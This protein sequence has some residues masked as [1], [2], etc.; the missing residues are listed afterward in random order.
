MVVSIQKETALI[1][2]LQNN[3]V[4]QKLNCL[5]EK[6]QTKTR[7]KSMPPHLIIMDKVVLLGVIFLKKMKCVCKTQM[8]PPPD[9]QNP[10]D[11]HTSIMCINILQNIKAVSLKL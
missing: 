3:D 5:K 6:N 2:T 4:A 9:H 8:M 10:V 7:K 1:K 11:M